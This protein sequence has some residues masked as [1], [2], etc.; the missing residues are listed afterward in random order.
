M[1]YVF[2]QSFSSFLL[3]WGYKSNHEE[4]HI[5]LKRDGHRVKYLPR[6]KIILMTCFITCDADLNSSEPEVMRVL[7]S[8]FL[9]CWYENSL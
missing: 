6:S 8:V 9:L 5:V 1:L 4:Q 3:P 7:V 2:R